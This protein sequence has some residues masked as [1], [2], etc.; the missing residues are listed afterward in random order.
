MLYSLADI[1]AIKRTLSTNNISDEVNQTINNL[2]NII[3]NRN[4]KLT[5][6]FKTVVK[7]VKKPDNIMNELRLNMN[8]LSVKNYRRQYEKMQ[9]S[10]RDLKIDAKERD[11]CAIMLFEL[12]SANLFFSELYADLYNKL[13]TEFEFLREPL[14]NSLKTFIAS[15]KNIENMSDAK[16][17]DMFCDIIKNNTKRIALLTFIIYLMKF[18]IVDGDMIMELTLYLVDNI[19]RLLSTGE[20]DQIEQ[21]SENLSVIIKLT[22]LQILSRGDGKLVKTHIER[23][24]SAKPTDYEGLTFKTIFKYMDMKDIIKKDKKKIL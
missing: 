10:L 24:A 20:S 19:E 23:L 7:K 17:Y 5:P 11:E 6:N 21:L 4:Y 3:S 16:N 13:Y 9:V 2:N 18:N 22:G 15:Y 8:K 12:A 1:Y 14:T